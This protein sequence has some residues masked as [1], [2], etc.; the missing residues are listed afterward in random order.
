MAIEKYIETQWEVAECFDSAIKTANFQPEVYVPPEIVEF[1][2][3]LRPDPRFAYV[4]TIAMSDGDRYGSNMNGDIFTEEELLGTQTAAEAAKNPGASQGVCLPRFKTFEDAKFFRGHDNSST[5]PFYGDV[6]L[7]AWND[8]MKRV[9]LIIRVAREMI[10]EMGMQGAPD[11]VIKLDRRGYISVSM[12]CRISHERCSYCG[13]ENEFVS[14]R[15]DHMRNRMG[16]IMPNGVKVAAINFGT[17]YFDISDVTVPADPI[18]NSLQKV[19]SAGPGRPNVAQDVQEKMSRWMKKWS[20]M[21]KT[22]PNDAIRDTAP[23]GCCDHVEDV[24]RLTKE[25]VDEVVKAASGDLDAIV[26]T[27]ALSA[28]VLSPVEL[29]ALTCAC[30]PQAKAAEA[31]DGFQGVALD[32]FSYSV[33]DALSHKIAARSGFVA[34]QPAAGWD[35]ATIEDGGHKLA[36]DYYSFYRACLG[37]LPRSTFVKAAHAVPPVRALHLGDAARVQRGL[38]ALAHAGLDSPA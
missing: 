29:A 23:R 34:P 25:E 6:P 15:C 27:S 17:R 2:R 20:E 26:A 30:E 36:A 4:H 7:A 8:Q 28:L 19:A 35:P 14:Q 33:Y 32:K 3:N 31:F 38:D 24:D 22:I 13:H 18:A 21:E 12:G 9:E 5:S 1:V 16:E 10:P 11:I 37:A